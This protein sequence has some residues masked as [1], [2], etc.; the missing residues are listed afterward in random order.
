MV[1]YGI[2]L[3]SLTAMDD[4][5]IFIHGMVRG[6]T[7]SDRCSP[8]LPNRRLAAPKVLPAAGRKTKAVVVRR[9]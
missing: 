4:G 2:S 7:Y 9:P 6:P 5:S 1:R 8:H 3:E